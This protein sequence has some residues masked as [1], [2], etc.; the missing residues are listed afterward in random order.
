LRVQ[1]A[2]FAK[3]HEWRRHEG[4]FKAIEEKPE[5]IENTRGDRTND[6]PN[7]LLLVTD[8]CSDQSPEGDAS[9]CGNGEATH[10]EQNLAND[11]RARLVDEANRL[12]SGKNP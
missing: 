1:R 4:V 5:G 11:M 8:R 12:G 9:G 7:R 10:R 6:R 3:G 2:L